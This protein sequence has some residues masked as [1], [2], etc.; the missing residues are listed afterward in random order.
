MSSSVEDLRS[1]YVA[2]RSQA[3]ALALSIDE[4]LTND[5]FRQHCLRIAAA[6]RPPARKWRTHQDFGLGD[7]RPKDGPGLSPEGWV[8]TASRAVS[9]WQKKANRVLQERKEDA[10]LSRLKIESSHRDRSWHYT[11]MGSL[12]DVEAWGEYIKRQ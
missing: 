11:V 1:T 3:Q 2:L 7:V 10:M 8:A 5:S 4:T 6:D 12:E 9:G